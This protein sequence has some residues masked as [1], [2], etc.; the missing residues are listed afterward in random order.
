LTTNKFLWNVPNQEANYIIRATAQDSEN[1]PQ[2]ASVTVATKITSSTHIETLVII[3]STAIIPF[4]AILVTLVVKKRIINTE[5]RK[6]KN[7]P[8]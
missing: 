1:P 4:S 2:T 8:S 3:S 5:T 6:N 7:K